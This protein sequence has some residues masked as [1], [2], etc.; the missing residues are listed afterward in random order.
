M[1]LPNY[2]GY[3]NTDNND[4]R[5]PLFHNINS[6][7]QY[8][9]HCAEHLWRHNKVYGDNFKCLPNPI[10]N[11]TNCQQ[12]VNY[13][14]ELDIIEFNNSFLASSLHADK[15]SHPMDDSYNFFA[16]RTTKDGFLPF[17]IPPQ[18]IQNYRV[19]ITQQPPVFIQPNEHEVQPKKKINFFSTKEAPSCLN[20]NN[21][22]KG[23]HPPQGSIFNNRTFKWEK[24]GGHSENLKFD[25]KEILKHLNPQSHS[26]THQFIQELQQNNRFKPSIE[27]DLMNESKLNRSFD[28]H[29]Y[30]YDEKWRSNESMLDQNERKRNF[31]GAFQSNLRLNTF[32][33]Q[34]NNQPKEKCEVVGLVKV[35]FNWK[36][37]SGFAN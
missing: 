16:S 7:E 18:E 17:L 19:P 1:I 13:W 31:S 15:T 25:E 6:E 33:D 5:G 22:P 8:I 26:T 29:N 23:N 10:F 11:T 14:G 20:K 9:Q 2:I 28:S 32:S 35:D 30:T 24:K 12:R 21:D 36:N 4:Y 3:Y 34:Y 27:K 37:S